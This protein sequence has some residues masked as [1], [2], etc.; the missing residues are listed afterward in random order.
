M[1]TTLKTILALLFV[2]T[3][4]NGCK[5]DESAYINELKLG[6][7]MAGFDLIGEGKTFSIPEGSVFLYFRLESA[8]DMAGRTVVLD[9]LT[10]GNGL[11]NTIT[12]EQAQ[13]YGHIILSSFEW[14]GGSGS[15]KINAYLADGNDK[16]FIATTDFTIN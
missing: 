14:L 7:G 13:D 15:F 12:R 8:D 16:I 4:F 1:K 6:T 5:K 3:I 2:S 11:I 10:S 9:F